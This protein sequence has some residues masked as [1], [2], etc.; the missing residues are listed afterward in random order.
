MTFSRCSSLTFAIFWRFLLLFPLWL[1]FYIILVVI[2]FLGLAD[3]AKSIPLLG[4]LL[5]FVV[6]PAISMILIMHP[7]LI[8][9][10]IGLRALGHET[11]AP[12]GRIFKIAILFGLFELVMA[13]IFGVLAFGTA[14]LFGFGEM[15]FQSAVATWQH[16][17]PVSGL[18]RLI[19]LGGI[20]V[21]PIL[22]SVIAMAF[23]AAILPAMAVAVATP[24][25]RFGV[26]SLFDGVG[27]NFVVMMAVMTGSVAVSSLAVP[28]LSDTAHHLGLGTLLSESL[29]SFVF[30]V[31]RGA[32]GHM[33]LDYA[34]VLFVT[35]ALSVLLFSL[36]CAA[37]ALS[38]EGQGNR[39]GLS[40]VARAQP[41]AQPAVDMA[42]LRRGRMPDHRN[43]Q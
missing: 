33:T 13:L 28:A 36:Q 22:G 40:R 25:K 11:R 4:I 16:A 24:P 29:G 34:V 17:D 12:E 35:I 32:V 30:L 39:V 19:G 15:D 3:L 6:P 38:Y 10:R 21:L 1:L 8:G 31:S 26:W 23:R 7:F 18:A 14:I 9:I 27:K 37:A 5:L 42:A 20:A 41:D 2:S 43:T